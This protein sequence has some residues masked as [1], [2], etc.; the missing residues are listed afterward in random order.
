MA[1]KKVTKEEI[2]HM[3]EQRSEAGCGT[4]LI[5]EPPCGNAA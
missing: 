2:E 5:A 4:W 1:D 3:K